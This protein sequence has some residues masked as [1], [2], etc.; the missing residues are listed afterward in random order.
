VVFDRVNLH[1]LACVLLNQLA[2]VLVNLVVGAQVEF[3]SKVRKQYI[4]F[5]LPSLEPDAVNTV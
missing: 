4:I 2:R 3:Q 1:R 5:Y